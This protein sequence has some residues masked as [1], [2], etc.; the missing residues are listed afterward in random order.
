MTTTPQPIRRVTAFRRQGGYAT[1]VRYTDAPLLVLAVVFLLVLIAPYAVH[2]TVTGKEAVDTA[3]VAIWAVFAI[4]YFA[5]LY[6]A[7]ERREYVKRNLLDLL[8]VVVPFLRPIR[9]VRL[10]RLLRV[11]TAAG[12]ASKRAT[13]LH[14]RVTAYVATTALVAVLLASFAMYDI[15]RDAR[16]GN[17]RTVGDA[18][19]W[20]VTTITTVGYGDHYPTTSEGK[21]VAVLLMVVGIALLGVITAT[22]AAWFVG[23]IQKVERVEAQ[24]QTQLEELLVEVRRLHLRLDAL[25]P[26]TR[27]SGPD[28]SR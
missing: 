9:A 18:L 8:I 12:L 21:L 15:E 2:L 5:R 3:N 13:S 20:S 19:W 6:L 22:I 27:S 17:I 7:L 23:H 24:S 28:P 11:G 25:E 1:W 10:L 4:D 26:V 16:G 14:A